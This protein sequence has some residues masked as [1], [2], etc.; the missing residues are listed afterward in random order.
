MDEYRGVIVA[1]QHVRLH[2]LERDLFISFLNPG[3]GV[4]TLLGATSPSYIPESNNAL[5]LFSTLNKLVPA[6]RTDP[7]GP[8][9]HVLGW[10]ATAGNHGNDS[11]EWADDFTTCLFDSTVGDLT[12]AGLRGFDRIVMGNALYQ[13]SESP[14]TTLTPSAASGTGVTF[15]AGSK[16]F[17]QTHVLASLTSG[18]ASAVIQS[19]GGVVGRN[20]VVASNQVIANISPNAP[21][22]ANTA[23]AAGSWRISGADQKG[24]RCAESADNTSTTIFAKSTWTTSDDTHQCS[25]FTKRIETRMLAATTGLIPKVGTRNLRVVT[26]TD[27]GRTWGS[28]VFDQATS[29]N[30]A[31]APAEAQ[32]RVVA[33]VIRFYTT[34]E[35]G[36]GGKL[37]AVLGTCANHDCA[38]SGYLNDKDF[39]Q[40]I[41]SKTTGYN[42]FRI[43]TLSN[44]AQSSAFKLRNP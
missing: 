26:S 32:R 39:T 20:D 44:P 30:G 23:I 18:N 12:F 10:S 33:E 28:V 34:M 4:T 13:V 3:C 11:A 29:C 25:I 24:L 1:S 16:V 15:T 35:F 27:G 8:R 43:P 37:N 31:C 2:P 22:V 21:F 41:D 40:V 19:I 14:L 9:V 38:G 36:H 7:P 6:T 17:N 5:S 42:T